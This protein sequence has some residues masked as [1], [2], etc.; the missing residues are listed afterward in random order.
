MGLAMRIYAIAGLG[1]VEDISGNEHDVGAFAS[2]CGGECVDGVQAS[3]EQ[4]RAG[5]FG[6]PA[7]RLTE[8]PV[9]CVYESHQLP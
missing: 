9:G 3:L 6:R 1:A 8:L 2:R 7:E 5:L 4:S